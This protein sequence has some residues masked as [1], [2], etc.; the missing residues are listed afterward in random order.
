MNTIKKIAVLALAT[1]ALMAVAA[2]GNASAHEGHFGGWHGEYGHYGH[3]GYGRFHDFGVGYY[4]SCYFV[5]KPWG[6]VK[7]CPE[8]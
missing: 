6:I 8:Y 3:W 2:T 7:V 1:G 4:G 5:T